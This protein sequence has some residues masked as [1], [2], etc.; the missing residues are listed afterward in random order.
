M[1]SHKIV[2]TGTPGAGKTT[3]I[4]ALSDKPPVVTDVRNTDALLDKELTTVGLDFGEVALG[5]GQSVRLLGTPGQL[6][7]EFMWRIIAND[8]LGLVILIDN[9]RPD[10]LDDLATYLNAYADMLPGMNC[11]VGVGRTLECPLPTIDEF[12]DLLAARGLVFP[13][14]PVDVRERDDVLMLVDTVLAQAETR[15]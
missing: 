9:S 10:P 6:R 8:A 7:F 15:D 12:S 13:V 3:A 5:D 1:K 4:T 11:A 14:L 2:F